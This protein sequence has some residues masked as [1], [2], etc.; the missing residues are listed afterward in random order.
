V[1]ERSVRDAVL[2]QVDVWWFAFRRRLEGLTDD[3]L[4]WEPAPGCW[5]VRPGD[6]G[7]ARYEWPPGSRGEQV[8]PFTTAAWRLCHI[9]VACLVGWTLHLERTPDTQAAIDATPFPL[10]AAE[11]IAFVEH[12]YERWRAAVGALSD[13]ELWGPISAF[14][15][16]DAPTMF[17]AADQPLVHHLLHQHRELIHHGAEVAL[18]R[19][20][21]RSRDGRP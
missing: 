3:E 10:T 20:L 12:W 18:L 4:L 19:D 13:D 21:Y 15:P 16:T 2:T 11:V 7:L 17:L 5:T 9:G 1:P 8:P 14:M 6:D